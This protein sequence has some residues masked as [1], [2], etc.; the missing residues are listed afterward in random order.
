MTSDDL[1]YLMYYQLG[2]TEEEFA[3]FIRVHCNVT[4]ASEE[5]IDMAYNAI[6][7]INDGLPYRHDGYQY[8]QYSIGKIISVWLE[9]S[10]ILGMQEA[11]SDNGF[12]IFVSPVGTAE[13]SFKACIDFQYGN[14]KPVEN[15][16]KMIKNDTKISKIFK[17]STSISTIYKGTVKIF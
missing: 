4:G 6:R 7:Y 16:P 15:Y 14:V 17:G 10:S 11:H 8:D 1:Y 9:I 5:A 2:Y 12:M 13:I 3:E